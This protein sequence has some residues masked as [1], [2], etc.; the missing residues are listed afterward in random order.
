MRS[1]L[2]EGIVRHRRLE[3]VEHSF[4]YRLFLVYVDLA[5]LDSLFGM[6]GVWSTRWPAVAR[7][8]RADYL[9][10]P[11]RSLDDCVREL[12]EQHTGSRPLGP[13]GLLT[14][15]R[16]FG[17]EMNP[18]SFYYCFDDSG[19]RVQTVV[20][21]VNNTPWNDKHCYVLDFANVPDAEDCAA[22]H[23]CEHPKEFHVS[24]FM[25]MDMDYHWRVTK[26]D[27]RLT[28]AI[29]NYSHGTKRFDATLS[30]QRRPITRWQLARVLVRYPFMTMQI[31]IGIYWQAFR[32]W[33]KRVPYFPHPR[34]AVPLAPASRPPLSSS[35]PIKP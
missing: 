32:L 2:Y 10:D 4:R 28:V 17:F 16:Y 22:I 5:E 8:R 23:R 11:A 3:P 34:H 29:E 12:V 26:P 6:R 31:F 24:P 15:F 20:A 9:G 27:E 13:I 30:L 33:L 18:V 19:N 21:E 14:S 25:R 35:V 1:C 7:F